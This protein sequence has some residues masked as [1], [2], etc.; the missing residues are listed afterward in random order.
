MMNLFARLSPLLPVMVAL[1]GCGD[2]RPER[3]PV[4]GQVLI[5]GEPLSYGTIRVVPEDARP[6]TA[7]LDEQGR[8]RLTCFGDEDGAVPGTHRVAVSAAEIL[9]ANELSG[10]SVIRWHA[11]K[12]YADFRT[13]GLTAEITGPTDDLT[14]E[15]SWDGGAPFVETEGPLRQR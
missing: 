8:F 7:R 3:V 14:V 12:H 10:R 11:P 6:S 2:G 4:A 1:L 5:D 15:L 13:S 9:E